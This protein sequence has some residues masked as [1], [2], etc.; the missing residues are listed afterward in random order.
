MHKR[1]SLTIKRHD[2][3]WNDP[4]NAT[5]LNKTGVLK[6][7]NFNRSIVYVKRNWHRFLSV[8]TSCFTLVRFLIFEISLNKKTKFRL[9]RY[10]YSCRILA[11]HART[12]PLTY[13]K[14]AT[15]LLVTDKHGICIF[16]LS[17]LLLRFPQKNVGQWV[18]CHSLICTVKCCDLKCH[19]EMK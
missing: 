10:R 14:H 8:S 3:F 15:Y 18:N 9:L 11:P 12:S 4:K 2:W 5:V 17:L 7:H 6:S 13:R 19:N 1:N 16:L